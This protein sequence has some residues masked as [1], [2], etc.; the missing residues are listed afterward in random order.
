MSKIRET[1]QFLLP[2]QKADVAKGNYDLY[3]TARLDKG[4][5]QA[6][7]QALAERMANEKIIIIDGY[8]GVFFK[9]IVMELEEALHQK[10]KVVNS[11]STQEA[12]KPSNEIDAMEH[13]K[14]KGASQWQQRISGQSS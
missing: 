14:V 6:G 12:L 13:N 3:P 10:G 11:I 9:E 1:K 8:V 2:L 7:S 5:I 4:A